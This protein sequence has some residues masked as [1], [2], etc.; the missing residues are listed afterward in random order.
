MLF[1]S[2]LSL[3]NLIEFCR[4]LRHSLGAGLSIRNVFRQQAEKG[5][6]AVRPIAGRISEEIEKGESLESALLFERRYF[7]SMFVSMAIVGEE[8]GCLPEVLK[9]LEQY[10]LLQQK[11][12]RQ[13]FSQ[14]AWPL[15]EYVLAGLVIPFMLLI[16]SMLGSNF[17]PLGAGLSGTKGAIV[18]ML[19]YYGSAV[20][21]VAAYLILTRTL[22]QAATVHA[23]L[24]RIPVIGP[25]MHAIALMRFCL[26]F[27]LTMETGMPVKRALRLS[28]N[29]TS[30][31]AFEAQGNTVEDAVRSGEELHMALSRSGVFPEDFLGII[32]NAEE[33]GRLVEVLENQADY[34]R[35]EASRK[36]AILSTAAA[37]GLY[38]LIGIT[39]IILILLIAMSIY[40]PGGAYDPKTYGL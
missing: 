13:F 17:A 16:L 21:L 25:C 39:I 20:L 8:T 28:M 3:K 33:S 5:A 22:N 38:A 34:Y 9:E 31:A 6:P 37:W 11:L 26:A 14:L 2:Q 10:F 1:S 32:S 24:L 27:R 40:G 19:F 23:F 4:V 30:N 35:D 29:A 15:V 7:P 18:F 12:R 36:M